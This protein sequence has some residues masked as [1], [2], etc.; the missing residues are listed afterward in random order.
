MTWKPPATESRPNDSFRPVPGEHFP[1]T[2]IPPWC[3]TCSKHYK[4]PI[5]FPC[6]TYQYNQ[7]Q[8]QS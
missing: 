7:N 8:V 3:P 1:D 2:G 4:C 5:K 6:G